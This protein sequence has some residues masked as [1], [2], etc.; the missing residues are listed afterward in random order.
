MTSMEAPSPPL[1]PPPNKDMETRLDV[2]IQNDPPEDDGGGGE[3]GEEEDEEEEEDDNG[4]KVG[5]GDYE[6]VRCFDEESDLQIAATKH[7]LQKLP[8]LVPLLTPVAPPPASA[9]LDLGG[10]DPEEISLVS[11]IVAIPWPAA[12]GKR[13]PR[14]MK[15]LNIQLW[16][17]VCKVMKWGDT[18]ALFMRVCS[19]AEAEV[20]FGFYKPPV[21]FHTYPF[22]VGDRL[23]LHLVGYSM[24][25]NKIA[26]SIRLRTTHMFPLTE[27]KLQWVV[28]PASKVETTSE[29]N[30][31]VVPKKQK[32]N[33]AA[34][35]VSA[36]TA[37]GPGSA[38]S[39]PRAPPIHPLLP[40][41]S[42]PYQEDVTNPHH[43]RKKLALSLPPIQ[44]SIL[45]A[46]AT[47]N[48]NNS[49][50]NFFPSFTIAAGSSSNINSQQQQQIPHKNSLRFFPT[51]G[52]AGSY[53]GNASSTSSSQQPPP[54]T[55]SSSAAASYT[56]TSSGF[57]MP[58]TPDM[59][60]APSFSF[61][62]DFMHVPSLPPPSP[63]LMTASST[64]A[65]GA[66]PRLQ[67]HASSSSSANTSTSNL[68]NSPSANC[69]PA[70][71]SSFGFGSSANMT[72]SGG[73]SS[74]SS[75]F[76]SQQQQPQQQP[77]QQPKSHILA[78]H[79]GG[80]GE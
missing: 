12:A 5:E 69:P 24:S 75:T 28:P 78:H 63:N 22:Q 68:F 4:S 47:S 36:A 26:T 10:Q 60:R 53:G 49:A 21:M 8:D 54:S 70:F 2:D 6:D 13:P 30:H 67:S 35:S 31:Q 17:V 66:L 20:D 62:N 40:L 74:S 11:R 19:L 38:H 48:N 3:N 79:N 57:H 34:A 43:K 76:V 14:D 25:R 73:P 64:A 16:Y 51:N 46:S 9:V 27:G 55:A 80:G 72:F 18:P 1:P 42:H 71:I 52:G 50:L 45:S 37:N 29:V 41:R 77:S 59:H 7:Q 44:T 39:S 58:G 33:S 65:G 32:S 61:M 56:I 15:R 23:Q